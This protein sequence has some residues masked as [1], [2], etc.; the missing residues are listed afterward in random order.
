M[1]EYEVTPRSRLR[2][3][4]DRASYDRDT[5]LTILDAGFLCH[6]GFVH[7]DSPRVI[8]FV[9]ARLG[10]AV[11]L[12]GAR[13]NR[14]LRS[15]CEGKEACVT[16]THLDGLV[17]ARSAFHNS[18]NFRSVVLWGHGCE[19]TDEARK[20][21]ALHATVDATVPGRWEDVRPPNP[22]EMKSVLVVEIPFDE[23]S[24]KVRTG[25]PIDD[26]ADMAIDC[27]AGVI[28]LAMRPG[29]PEPDA[30]LRPGIETPGY[31]S[32]YDR[33]DVKGERRR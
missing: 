17:L 10:D 28:P 19:V 31:V 30:L 24:A 33:V 27:W 11:Y 22:D 7:D 21:E 26:D 15:L 2:R 5:L 3:K 29:A 12:H 16:V 9:Y 18:V 25:G 13:G 8:P 20:M 4:A 14:A 23:A 6:V 32:G 1:S